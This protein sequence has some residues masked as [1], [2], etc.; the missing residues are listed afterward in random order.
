MPRFLHGEKVVAVDDLPPAAVA[1][2]YLGLP[3]TVD[4]GHSLERERKV[5]FFTFSCGKYL[6]NPKFDTFSGEILSSIT[7]PH[8]LYN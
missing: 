8:K 2:G 5:H 4:H 6:F 7:F 1:G 3:A